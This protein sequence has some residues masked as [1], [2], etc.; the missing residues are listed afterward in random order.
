MGHRKRRLVTAVTAAAVAFMLV[1][2]L[3][4]VGQAT[5]AG[6]VDYSTTN[7]V[8]V[9][10]M[11]TDLASVPA[12]G[13]IKLGARF[14]SVITRSAEVRFAIRAPGG[15]NV[16]TPI[17][18]YSMTTSL[19]NFE[20]TKVVPAT[21]GTYTW[22][23]EWRNAGTSTWTTEDPSRTFQVV[24]A[25]PSA[26]ASPAVITQSVT[27]NPATTVQAV[28]ASAQVWA[29]PQTVSTLVWACRTPTNG[30]CDFG[31]VTN[32]AFTGAAQTFSSARTFTAAGTYTLW[33]LTRMP[34]AGMTSRRRSHW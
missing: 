15:A 3:A 32:F 33:V 10:A 13:S 18:A 11:G 8:A 4:G 34:P 25:A 30:N 31:H 29:Q 6:T 24:S 2:T 22:W 9:Q 7:S 1:F 12:G 19:Q 27:P 26:P 17:T 28:T 21:I 23:F 16:D 20:A 5:P 14:T